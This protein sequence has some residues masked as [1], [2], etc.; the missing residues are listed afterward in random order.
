MQ[1]ILCLDKAFNQFITKART[2][3]RTRLHCRRE[4]KRYSR[5]GLFDF[6]VHES[7]NKL[8]SLQILLEVLGEKPAPEHETLLE[9]CSVI[10]WQEKVSV[11]CRKR[12]AL[13]SHLAVFRNERGGRMHYATFSSFTTSR[14]KASLDAVS[15][16]QAINL[17]YGYGYILQNR[18]YMYICIY[19]YTSMALDYT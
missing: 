12:P 9:H 11:L 5:R 13:Y 8:L 10:C 7:Q 6:T 2:P 18:F 17:L 16:I 19:L 4:W 3:A 15:I 1:R 14:A